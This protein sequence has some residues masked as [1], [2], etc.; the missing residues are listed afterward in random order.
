MAPNNFEFDF[1]QISFNT[2]ESRDGNI[3]QDDRDPDLN[4]F[5]ETNI[6]SKETTYINETDMRHKDLRT[7]LFFMLTPDD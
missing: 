7:F 6:L 5:D 4:Y 2:F 3:F 1:A